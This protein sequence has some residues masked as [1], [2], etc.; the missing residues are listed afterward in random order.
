MRNF[1]L[2]TFGLT[3]G[4]NL[5]LRG[6]TQNCSNKFIWTIFHVKGHKDYYLNIKFHILFDSTKYIQR[7]FPI[8]NILQY[9]R[10]YEFDIFG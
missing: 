6:F 10:R 9:Q 7:F 3:F 1:G 2:L 8:K 5:A 4:C